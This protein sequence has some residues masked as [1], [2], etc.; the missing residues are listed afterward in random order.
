M[1]DIT[2]RSTIFFEFKKSIT[3]IENAHLENISYT[4]NLTVPSDLFSWNF[5]ETTNKLFNL[6]VQKL[7][8]NG[9]QISNISFQPI[10]ILFDRYYEFQQI[11]FST[12]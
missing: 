8:N 4:G 1:S 7:I 11:K 10:K 6:I 12:N 9:G 3:I 5:C 2:S